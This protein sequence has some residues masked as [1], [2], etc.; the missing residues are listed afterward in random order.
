MQQNFCTD[1]TGFGIGALN[2]VAKNI[3]ERYDDFFKASEWYN[4]VNYLREA[5]KLMNIRYNIFREEFEGGKNL[6]WM[7]PPQNFSLSCIEQLPG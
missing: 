2:L 1:T 4:P 3:E 7:C 5:S 6:Y